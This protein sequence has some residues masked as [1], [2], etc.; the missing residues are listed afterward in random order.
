MRTSE[1]IIEKW[2]NLKLTE[3]KEIEVNVNCSDV[4]QRHGNIFLVGLVV[5]DKAINR[6]AFK[7]TALSIWR[8]QG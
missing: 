7:N 2:H 6:E 5:S 8:S 4:F 3:A 1:E